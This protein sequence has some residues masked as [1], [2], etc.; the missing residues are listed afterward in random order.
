MTSVVEVDNLFGIKNSNRTAEQ[1]LGKNQ[2]NSSFPTALANY[3]MS[4]KKSIMYNKVVEIDG[5]LKV[6]TSEISVDKI[7]K[8]SDINKLYF[9]FETVYQPYEKYS[10]DTIDGIDLSVKDINDNWLRALE[11]KLTVLPDAVT[12]KKDE[13]DNETDVPFIRDKVIGRRTEPKFGF[14][15][16][17]KRR[18]GTESNETKRGDK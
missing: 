11:V 13:K 4:K 3:M 17:Y 18:R 15:L 5:E 9:S 2:F 1:H 16:M 12:S 14:G 7:F 8:T 10:F 6:E